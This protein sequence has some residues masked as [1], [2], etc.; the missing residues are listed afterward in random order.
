MKYDFC[1]FQVDEPKNIHVYVCVERW[2]RR[3]K[4][5]TNVE[6][7][8]GYSSDHCIFF[9]PQL[10]FLKKVG[11][12]QFSYKAG[13][14]RVELGNPSDDYMAINSPGKMRLPWTGKGCWMNWLSMKLTCPLWFMM[15]VY[16]YRS[17]YVCI[18]VVYMAE[19][20]I[21]ERQSSFY[22]ENQS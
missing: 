1:S 17:P 7:G 11:G 22:W 4:L 9:P 10:F 3:G 12:K 18:S 15:C 2:S 21:L 5:L 8:E 13:S 16:P 19:K 6:L 20:E 14:E